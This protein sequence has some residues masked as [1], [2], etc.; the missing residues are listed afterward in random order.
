MLEVEQSV[1]VKVEDDDRFH[2]QWSSTREGSGNM[3]VEL[4]FEE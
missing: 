4:G 3:T 2:L 1:A